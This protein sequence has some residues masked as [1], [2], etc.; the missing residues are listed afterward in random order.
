[1]AYN[2]H[3]NALPDSREINRLSRVR[4]RREKSR[5][6][7]KQGRPNYE[8]IDAVSQALAK[9]GKYPKRQEVE[10]LVARFLKLFGIN[11]IAKS[12]NIAPTIVLLVLIA[13]F[14]GACASVGALGKDDDISYKSKVDSGDDKKDQDSAYLESETSDDIMDE[15]E[16]TP[17]PREFT[18]T[19]AQFEA[20]AKHLSPEIA[21]ILEE[22]LHKTKNPEKISRFLV[23][24]G[25]QFYDRE[26]VEMVIFMLKFGADALEYGLDS[27]SSC[28]NIP[29][30]NKEIYGLADQ[31]GFIDFMEQIKLQTAL[32]GAFEINEIAAQKISDGF[33]SRTKIII[34]TFCAENLQAYLK[35]FEKKFGLSAAIPSFVLKEVTSAFTEY[36]SSRED[37]Q[38][39]RAIVSEMKMLMGAS[40]EQNAILLAS[41]AFGNENI[42]SN[43]RHLH[44]IGFQFPQTLF[45][46]KHMRFLE[47]SQIDE[48]FFDFLKWVG[49]NVRQNF[50][51]NRLSD[52][53]EQY[54][55]YDFS[56]MSFTEELGLKMRAAL[57]QAHNYS[58]Q[59][60]PFIYYVAHQTEMNDMMRAYDIK[61]T[62]EELGQLAKLHLH[63]NKEAETNHEEEHPSKILDPEIKSLIDIIFKGA[64][65][66]YTTEDGAI[67]GDQQIKTLENAYNS[68]VKLLKTRSPEE[69]RGLRSLSS[70]GFIWTEFDDAIYS[71]QLWLMTKEIERNPAGAAEL[72]ATH[73]AMGL[74]AE[75]TFTELQ[76]LYNMDPKSRAFFVKFCQNLKPVL[77]SLPFWR[78]TEELRVFFTRPDLAEKIYGILWNETED[79]LNNLVRDTLIHL[80]ELFDYRPQDLESFYELLQ[81]AE[82]FAKYPKNLAEIFRLFQKYGNINDPYNNSAHFL[83][84][85][86]LYV[87][88]EYQG[89]KLKAIIVP[90]F[91]KNS[92]NPNLQRIYD[93]VLKQ[94]NIRGNPDNLLFDSSNPKDSPSRAYKIEICRKLLSER[95]SRW[96]NKIIELFDLRIND[97]RDLEFLLF[98]YE[99]PQLREFLI[100][101]EGIH[102]YTQSKKNGRVYGMWELDEMHEDYLHRDI[103]RYEKVLEEKFGISFRQNESNGLL[104]R[105][106]KIQAI[107]GKRREIK[108]LDYLKAI[109]NGNFLEDLGKDETEV[110][111]NELSMKFGIKFGQQNFLHFLHINANPK[112]YQ[113]LVSEDFMAFYQKFV[114]EFPDYKNLNL[115]D[116]DFIL[117]AYEVG[118]FFETFGKVQAEIDPELSLYD[119]EDIESI[120]QLSASPKL[121]AQICNDEVKERAGQLKSKNENFSPKVLQLIYST[122]EDGTSMSDLYNE[123]FDQFLKIALQKGSTSFEER[124]QMITYYRNPESRAMIE[125]EHYKEILFKLG[126]TKMKPDLIQTVLFFMDNPDL[127]KPF[128]ERMQDSAGLQFEQ[129]EDRIGDPGIIYNHLP[130]FRLLEKDPKVKEYQVILSKHLPYIH[131]VA[132]GFA[133]KELSQIYPDHASFEGVCKI[134]R[135]NLIDAGALSQKNGSWKTAFYLNDFM[136]LFK[137][138]A[139]FEY[140]RNKLESELIKGLSNDI[141]RTDYNFF[142]YTSYNDFTKWNLFELNKLLNLQRRLSEDFQLRAQIAGQIQY[143][144]EKELVSEVGFL[145]SAEGTFDY[146]P[147][148]QRFANSGYMSSQTCYNQMMGA[149]FNGH[150]HAINYNS[151]RFAS[152]SGN[153]F[154]MGSDISFSALYHVDGVVITPIGQGKFAV[155]ANNDRKD[156]VFLGLFYSQELLEAERKSE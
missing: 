105:M 86:N 114:S 136:P 108:A 123:E 1:M 39:I 21:Q 135:R 7:S 140:D 81:I 15:I 143:D 3:Y 133:L 129:R 147:P 30:A 62:D 45:W 113:K 78:N 47:L 71:S 128:K 144:I 134:I 79:R 149:S 19:E 46:E 151:A 61:I 60:L 155:H 131:S 70:Q 8:V 102:F 104:G 29:D 97:F 130:S 72:F 11:H 37:W 88:D 83:G 106:E 92:T 16:C 120:I 77:E 35:I 124:L 27:L 43:I 125:S 153:L 12:T 156:V 87:I 84:I 44:S 4:A 2:R 23:K 122:I 59:A 51:L 68:A 112:Y 85:L 152:P 127:I 111:F 67:H 91:T 24:F 109:K 101:E 32:T 49:K 98:K 73:H 55:E 41:L 56:N 100:S 20:Y 63:V 150:Q 54:Q 18:Y 64:K 117:Q 22:E 137:G 138:D 82:K 38:K 14:S 139:P 69:I 58:G 115:I 33:L 9:Q 75:L 103:L 17:G 119:F 74:T 57:L 42:L 13:G 26:G 95:V 31:I 141:H 126:F 65:E 48:G 121:L 40:F 132:D 146:I 118:N 25:I 107:T 50:S 110:R 148:K 28:Y 34:D 94:Y 76:A 6:E 90:E 10:A 116:L 96:I 52:I 142:S 145:I 5:S 154:K 89:I 53:Y 93:R 80:Q 99:N 36:P 66:K